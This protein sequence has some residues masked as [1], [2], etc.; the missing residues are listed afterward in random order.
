MVDYFGNE[1]S[2]GDIVLYADVSKKEDDV[3]TK[4]VKATFST[5]IVVRTTHI[6]A[7]T[8]P[9]DGWEYLVYGTL[10]KYPYKASDK[11][12]GMR[13]LQGRN[14]INL[15]ALGRCEPIDL[16]GFVRSMRK[17]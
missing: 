11:L 10:D 13:Q 7:T 3:D 15:V 2:V 6:H 8:I 16:D 4:R 1:I 12:E 17:C 9:Y 5:G 14:T